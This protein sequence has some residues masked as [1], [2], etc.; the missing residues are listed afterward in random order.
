MTTLTK[1]LALVLGASAL[2]LLPSSTAHAA[3]T[4]LGQPATIEASSGDVEGTPADDVIVVSGKV[5]FVR[6]GGGD[7]LICLDGTTPFNSN[8]QISVD[9]GPGADT[10][11]AS[12]AGAKVSARLPEG[13]DSFIGSAFDDY[14]VVG[15]TGALLGAPGDP[16]PFS[17]TTGAGKD[18]LLIEVGAV[19]GADLGGG[20]DGVRVRNAEGGAPH[21]IDLGAGRDTASFEDEWDEFGAAGET[22]LIVNLEQ[23]VA[24]WHGVTSALLGAENIRAVARRIRVRGDDGPNSFFSFGCDVVFRG[25][26]GDDTTTMKTIGIYDTQPFDCKPGEVRRAYGNKGDDFLGGG[27]SHDVLV[28]GPGRDKAHGGPGGDDVCIAEIVAGKGCVD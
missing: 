11:D 4:C 28:G 27:R 23:D 5:R 26:R 17:V 20:S 10:V 6:A 15:S 14:V 12:K 24:Q 9:S 19:V 25:G 1:T 2:T 13:E 8:R 18:S 3:G 7:D 22:S 16:G 21:H